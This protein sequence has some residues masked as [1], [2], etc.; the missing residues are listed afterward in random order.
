VW[1]W[2]LG[3]SRHDLI[4]FKTFAFTHLTGDRSS[5]WGEIGCTRS[6]AQYASAPLST[7]NY[8]LRETPRF[9]VSLLGGF[10]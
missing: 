8:A 5:L 3:V 7:T 1:N 2:E 4:C 10:H 9:L 6:V